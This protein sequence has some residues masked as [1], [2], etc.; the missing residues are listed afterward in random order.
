MRFHTKAA[1][2]AVMVA[3]VAVLLVKMALIRNRVV[4]GHNHLAALRGLHMIQ[5]IPIQLRERHFKVAMAV[6]LLIVTGLAEAQVAA[7]ITAAVAARVGALH[8]V[9]VAV[10]LAI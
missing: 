10:A 6:V 9:L 1:T 3:R 2:P 8:R 7:G 5:I 4:V